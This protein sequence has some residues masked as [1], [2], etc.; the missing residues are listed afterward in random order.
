MSSVLS[1]DNALKKNKPREK[2]GNTWGK[3]V[4]EDLNHKPCRYLWKADSKRMEEQRT[5]TPREGHAAV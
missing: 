5:K 1:S 2:M 3:I 4:T